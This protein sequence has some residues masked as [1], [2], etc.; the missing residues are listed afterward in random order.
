MLYFNTILQVTTHFE[1]LL[2]QVAG[3]SS[4]EESMGTIRQGMASLNISMDR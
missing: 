4:L 1:D 2:Q 3:L